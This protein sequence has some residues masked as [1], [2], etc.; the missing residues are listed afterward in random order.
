[1]L[2]NEPRDNVPFLS[3]CSMVTQHCFQTPTLRHLGCEELGQ[4]K[5]RKKFHQPQSSKTVRESNGQSKG[6]G[7]LESTPHGAWSSS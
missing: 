4:E 1:M 2:M 5:E 3:T 7:G 6:L